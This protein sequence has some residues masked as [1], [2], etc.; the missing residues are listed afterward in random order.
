MLGGVQFLW[1]RLGQF[2]SSGGGKKQQEASYFPGFKPD[3]HVV[4]HSHCSGNF[5]QAAATEPPSWHTK[6][7]QSQLR[8]NCLGHNWEDTCA[9]TAPWPG[10]IHLCPHKLVFYMEGLFLDRSAF[11]HRITPPPLS[12]SRHRFTTAIR[13]RPLRPKGQ[14]LQLTLF[15]SNGAKIRHILKKKF[16]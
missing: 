9:P 2:G 12:Q 1:P 11:S 4:F 13:S 6:Q 5:A 14:Y 16:T 3:G 7:A 10:L 8:Q 15:A